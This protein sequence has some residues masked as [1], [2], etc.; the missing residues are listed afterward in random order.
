MGQEIFDAIILMI[1][2]VL[3]ILTVCIMQ[4]YRIMVNNINSLASNIDKSLLYKITLIGIVAGTIFREGAEIMLFVYSIVSVNRIDVSN[5]LLSIIIAGSFG[6]IF[7]ILMYKGL[8]KFANKYIFK[9]SSI[10]FSMI[11]ASLF[12]ESLKILISC[13]IINVKAEPIFHLGSIVSEYGILGFILKILIG[14]NGAMTQIEL[15]GYLSVIAFIVSFTMIS[16]FTNKAK[17]INTK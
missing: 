13:D 4:N 12:A 3:L 5:Y 7:G 9:V 6:I 2:S 16:K 11:A 10:L 17:L 15:L 8:I 1:T 14:Y